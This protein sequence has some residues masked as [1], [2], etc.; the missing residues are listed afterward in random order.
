MAE[1]S[2]RSVPAEVARRSSGASGAQV[3]RRRGRRVLCQSSGLQ[4]HRGSSSKLLQ[5][6]SYSQAGCRERNLRQQRGHRLPLGEL[7]VLQQDRRRLGC[8]QQEDRKRLIRSTNYPTSLRR[9]VGVF[10][11]RTISTV[12][13]S[14]VNT[15]CR[16]TPRLRN[17]DRPFR[18]NATSPP[19]TTIRRHRA[20]TIRNRGGSSTRAPSGR[21]EWHLRADGTRRRS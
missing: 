7:L 18:S 15:F 12:S 16:S 10:Y 20:L 3:G 21:C 19:S 9:E 8:R 17:L 11:A 14:A 6:R 5:R 2:P 4:R 1:G 13:S